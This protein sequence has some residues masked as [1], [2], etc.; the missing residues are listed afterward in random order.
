M[1]PKR[2]TDIHHSISFHIIFW[3]ILLLGFHETAQAQFDF[4]LKRPPQP[5]QS[6]YI[7][8]MGN[9]MAYSLN[10][11][12]IF[13]NNLGI[14][15]G[16]SAFGSLHDQSQGSND[17][18]TKYFTMLFMGNYYIGHGR[19]RLQLG[20]GYVI[21][22]MGSEPG[23]NPPAITMTIAYRMLPVKDTRYTLKIGFTPFIS[24]RTFYPSIG[25]AF[26]WVLS[27]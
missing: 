21:G 3:G 7:E 5:T 8:L 19:S 4:P 17:E 9:G 1:S 22:D 13:K 25:I 10:Y 23:L 15:I 11:D 20:A 14:R 16:G 12:V 6:A 26:G 27:N 18:W 2:I 24:H